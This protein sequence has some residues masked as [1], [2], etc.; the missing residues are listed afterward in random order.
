MDIDDGYTSIAMI[1]NVSKG[2]GESRVFQRSSEESQHQ[3]NT[4]G[5]DHQG[6][7]LNATDAF[8][9]SMGVESLSLEETDLAD[10]MMDRMMDEVQVVEVNRS[11]FD[12]AS[13]VAG[14]DAAASLRILRGRRRR[15]P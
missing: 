4:C 9:Q 5:R 3:G 10:R 8:V 14:G 15:T 6:R 7:P 11:F 12:P 1:H 13:G 2:E